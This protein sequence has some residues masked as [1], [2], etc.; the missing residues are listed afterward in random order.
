MTLTSPYGW[1]ME[2]PESPGAV[3]VGS[4]ERGSPEPGRLSRRSLLVGGVG[5]GVGAVAGAAVVELS[6]GSSRSTSA[7]STGPVYDV[8]VVGAGLGGLTAARE[9]ERAGRSVLVLEARDRVGGRTYD[10][11]VDHDVEVELGGEWTG[12]G[13]TR[14]QALAREFG[15]GTFDSYSHG[16]S[17]YYRSGALRTYQGILPP[18][19]ATT[20]AD[21]LRL[22]T[23]LN[24]M[25]SGVPAASPWTATQAATYDIQ[26]AASFF[27]TQGMTAEANFLA[28]L[29]VRSNYGEEA[30]QV[31]LMDALQFIAGVGGNY[32]TT[33]GS[34]QSVRFVGGPQRLSQGLAD[35]LNS[36]VQLK[37]PVVAVERGKVATVQAASGSYRARQVILAIPKSVTAAVRFEPALPP[38]WAQY[39]QRQPTGAT[40]KI[41]AVYDT[42]FWRGE[43]LNGAVTSDTG[44]IEIV[45]DNSPP[46]G[47]RGVLVGFAEG[48]QGRSLFGLSDAA[49]RSAVLASLARYFGARAAR[50]VAYADLVWAREP[51]SG[52]AYGSY[53]PPG[54]ITSLAEA[55]TGPIGN[56]HFAGAD[57]AAE[58]PGYMEGA[59]RSGSAVAS[60]VLHSL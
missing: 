48:N 22:I 59:I 37:S 25:A 3:H 34:A 26:S 47:R 27:A 19:D 49:R 43:G 29:S 10:V 39:F 20:L 54:V 38:A 46:D 1:P 9:L 12:P 8:V 55:T 40:V 15:V 23:T 57:Y 28:A 21:L 60:T 18:T 53:N 50:P 36:K 31:G 17:I 56:L 35:R 5:V 14:V 52:G 32:V 13:Q 2:S 51:F 6:K 45:Y 7:A 33:L 30:S 16:N 24:G 11:V 41:E 4:D 58:W 42:P 44:P